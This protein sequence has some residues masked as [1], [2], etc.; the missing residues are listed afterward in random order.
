MRAGRPL[1]LLLILQ[2]GGRI[3]AD[4]LAGRLGVST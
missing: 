4:E 3:T 1:S 2:N